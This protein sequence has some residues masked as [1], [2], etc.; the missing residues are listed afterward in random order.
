MIKLR[1]LI[2]EIIL[3]YPSGVLTRRRQKGWSQRRCDEEAEGRE[4]RT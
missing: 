1:T 2:E 3:D 4:E